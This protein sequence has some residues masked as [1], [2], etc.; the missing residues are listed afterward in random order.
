ML[1][2]DKTHKLFNNIKAK[3]GLTAAVQW[4]TD[5]AMHNPAPFANNLELSACYS[6]GE[7]D[8]DFHNAY[9]CVYDELFKEV[10]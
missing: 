3:Q 5:E 4:L 9:R 1:Y 6:K 7:L 10:D 8:F 2:I